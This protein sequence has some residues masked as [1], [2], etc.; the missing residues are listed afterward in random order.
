LP[1]AFLNLF[2]QQKEKITSQLL[3]TFVILTRT[4]TK[5]NG[6][7]EKNKIEGKKNLTGK[8]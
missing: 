4:Q 3:L 7:M 8:K 2:I 1:D 5:Q 6:K